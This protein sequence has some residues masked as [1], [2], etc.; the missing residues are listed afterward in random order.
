MKKTLSITAVA[1]A[2]AGFGAVAQAEEARTPANDDAATARV[3]E[4]LPFSEALDIRGATLEPD[5]TQPSCRPIRT[6]VWYALSV[7]EDGTVI[8]EMSSTFPSA[9]AVLAAGPDGAPTELACSDGQAGSALEFDAVPGTVYLIQVGKTTR[10]QGAAD[11]SFRMSSWKEI[12]LID[13]VVERKIDEQRLPLAGVKGRPRSS[14]PAM[15]DVTI[16]V[17]QEKHSFGILT[18]GLVRRDFELNLVNVPAIA[19]KIR[20]QVTG[21]YDSSQYRCAL[22]DGAE[23]CYAGV[24]MRDLT[25]LTGGDGSRAELVVT[26]S[27]EKDGAVLVQR[28][29]T[30]PYAGQVLGLIP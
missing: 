3:V 6:S 19:T 24:P 10:K 30:I 29:Q 22:D 4:G 17:G 26:I 12:T 8:A 5:E 9:M 20:L 27:A 28:S 14:D 11:V 2:V 1:L 18:Y 16:G 7:P 23:T 13:Q 25:W 21:R 15:Y